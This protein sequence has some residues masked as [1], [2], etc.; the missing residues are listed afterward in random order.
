LI[1]YT[2]DEVK[3]TDSLGDILATTVVKI[4]IVLN[5]NILLILLVLFGVERSKYGVVPNVFINRN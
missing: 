1:R 5:L 3:K 2:V 4:A